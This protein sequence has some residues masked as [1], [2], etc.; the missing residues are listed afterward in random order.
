MTF[1]LLRS[2]AY[3]VIYADPPWAFRGYVTDGVPQRAAD[4]N[5]PTMTMEELCAL[6]VGDLAKNNCALLMWG[7]ASHLPQA[8]KLGQAWGFEFKS[9]AFC[10]A[11]LNKRFADQKDWSVKYA[12][13]ANSDHWFMGMGYGTRRNT[14]DCW[15]FTRGNP[16]RLSGGVR[17]LVVAPVREHSRKPSEVRERIEALYPGPYAE[18]F[19]R[20]SA[21]GW[22]TWGNETGKFDVI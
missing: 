14:E 19:S 10:W 2:R 9:K 16:R 18:L 12:S 4:Q 20:E 5:Y 17:E 3:G 21:P 15:L 22:E 6:P 11:K 7:I 13:P 8:I 1:G